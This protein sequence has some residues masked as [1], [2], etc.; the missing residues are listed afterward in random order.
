MP[1]RLPRLALLV[2]GEEKFGTSASRAAIENLIAEHSLSSGE[3]K[4]LH[5]GDRDGRN[6]IKKALRDGK[7]PANP[8]GIRPVGILHRREGQRVTILDARVNPDRVWLD[9]MLQYLRPSMSTGAGEN[10]SEV[11]KQ[12]VA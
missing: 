8:D 12:A 10:D 4:I 9:D 2:G 7:L 3:A 5:P 11:G 6:L 1:Q